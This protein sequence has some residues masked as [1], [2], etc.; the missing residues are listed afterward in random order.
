MTEVDMLNSWSEMNSNFQ[1]SNN[2]THLIDENPEIFDGSSLFSHFCSLWKNS[3][4]SLSEI[5]VQYGN[6]C[7][8]IVQ[9]L[10]KIFTEKS[11]RK[12]LPNIRSITEMINLERNTWNLI[13]SIYLDRFESETK[14]GTVEGNDLSNFNHSEREII[15]LLYE[16]DNELRETQIL[17]DWLERI[18]REQIEEVAEKYE[19]LFN[20]TTAW[21]NTAHLLSYLSQAELSK[22]RLVKE[23][24][25]DA[26]NLTGNELDQKDQI[27]NDR[28]MNYL[29]LCLRG[30]DLRR[31]QLLCTQRGEFWRAISL[32]GWRPFH[33]SGFLENESNQYEVLKNADEN[34]TAS[35]SFQMK[36]I[37]EGNPTRILYKSVCWWNAENIKLRSFERAIYAT[38]S[39]NLNV[40]SKILPASWTDQTWAHCR[41]LVE[42]RVDSSLRSLLNTGPR[43]DTLAVT[44][45]SSKYWP[46]D[47]GLS[48][49]ES[50]WTPGDWTLSNVFARVD[51]RLGW[52]AIGC[53][54]KCHQHLRMK[55]IDRSVMNDFLL[56]DD[57]SYTGENND[58]N[59]DAHQPQQT[60][61][62]YAI[63]YCIFYGVQQTIMLKNYNAFLVTLSNLMPKLVCYGL[64]DEIVPDVIPLQPPNL[65]KIGQIN[66]IVCHTLRFLTHFVLFLKSADSDILD[67]PCAEIIKA[68]LCFLIVNKEIDLIAYYIS[69]LS[70]ESVQIQWY[71]WFLTEIHQPMEREHCLSLAVNYGFNLSKL[72]RSIVKLSK[73]RIDLCM[74]QQYPSHP[75][76]SH[77][78]LSKQQSSS[79]LMNEM[80]FFTGL[81]HNTNNNMSSN[82][83]KYE[84]G[85]LTDLDKQRII[86]LDW[87]FYNPEQRGEALCLANSLLRVFIAMHSFKSAQQV[88]SK[89][90]VGTLEHAK[91]ICE[92]LNSPDWLVN[93]IRE[94]ECLILY[95]ESRDAFADWYQQVH[96]NRPVQPSILINN[97][98]T[99]TNHHHHHLTHTTYGPRGLAQ[100]LVI[101]ESKK[102]YL[103]RLERWR[104]DTR[105]DT[106]KAAEKLLA[107]LTYPYPGWLVNIEQSKQQQLKIDSNDRLT[108]PSTTLTT[109]TTATM[110]TTNTNHMNRG[111]TG[112]GELDDGAEADDESVLQDEI[113]SATH[114]AVV[115]KH[116]HQQ[117][118]MPDK[119]DADLFDG[120]GESVESR[121]LQMNV[122]R[123]TCITETVFLIVR[124]YQT[125]GLHQKCIEL[126]NLIVD[127]KFNLYKLFSGPQLQNLLH[128][129]SESIQ[130]FIDNEQ[131]PL[132][133]PCSLTEFT[134]AGWCLSQKT[135]AEYL[136]KTD[137]ET[138]NEL[139]NLLL[140]SDIRE[141]GS[142]WLGDLRKASHLEANG[143]IVQLIRLRNISIPQATE[144]LMLTNSSDHRG[145]CLLRFTFTDGRNQIS[146]LD[147]QNKSDLNIDIPPGTKFRLIG[148]IPLLMG[149][150]LLSKKHI[151]VLGGT[152]NNLIR[153]WN[154]TKFLKGTE[155]R[156]I[157]QGAP[158]FVPFGSREASCLIQTEG[159]FLNQLRSD[160]ERNQM[161]F[162]SFQMMTNNRSDDQEESELQTQFNEHRKEV[163]AELKLSTNHN[164]NNHHQ[165]SINNSVNHTTND[166][167]RIFT[168]QKS[169]RF[170]P[171]LSKFYE[172]QSK[173]SLEYDESLS[174]LL[175][176]G[177]P[178][179]L[180][181][182]A[183]KMHRYNYQ[184]TIDYLLS[185]ASTSILHIE[186]DGDHTTNN[187]NSSKTYYPNNSSRG[188]RSHDSNPSRRITT[189]NRGYHDRG[190]RGHQRYDQFHSSIEP[191]HNTTTTNNNASLVVRPSMGLTRLDD[192][193]VVADSTKSMTPPPT[194]TSST[195]NIISKTCILPIGCPI[196]AQNISGDYVEAQLIGHF[197]RQRN[198]HNG[199]HVNDDVGNC[200]EK[201][202]LVVYH[203]QQKSNPQLTIDE[204]EIVPINLIRTL[205]KEKITIDMV[206][207]AP[208]DRIKPYC[209]PNSQIDDYT[210]NVN[211]SD[212][213]DYSPGYGLL[214]NRPYQSSRGGGGRRGGGGGRPHRT[215]SAG[216]GAGGAGGRR[217]RGR[218]MNHF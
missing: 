78:F 190:H 184:A 208:L 164:N 36:F 209:L 58:V 68:Y 24:H 57:I 200:K 136:K 27:D 154:M 128:H 139:F 160:R 104:H 37:A 129:I 146:G 71:S 127:N 102:D 118:L 17:I 88:L 133:Y 49:P 4:T 106:E 39:G 6:A 165:E 3:Q 85:K 82:N 8:K 31:A 206:P 38:L 87:L 21:E 218:I 138:Y 54:E 51:A 180:A 55:S 197:P 84:I 181:N 26:V 176:L 109:T 72:T 152:V 112:G 140:N 201:V 178:F 130:Y 2:I 98:N 20:Q 158:M 91:L 93:T 213:M 119:N 66:Q 60:P 217:S 162:D 149:F 156:V 67:E 65:N 45:K 117:T 105:L 74:N 114:T 161:K 18:V 147:M 166:Q 14:T 86:A 75:V 47:G 141:Y 46:L 203:R 50:A 42:A 73:Q 92:K 28:L 177:Y 19:C 90:P 100:R 33:Y 23:L 216:R 48:L 43:A 94:H 16:R 172:I 113:E 215:F 13:S 22:H 95:L 9:R 134:N 10:P 131:D 205:N 173:K 107:L 52:S 125:A 193:I 62:I 182:S 111:G 174:K 15:R 70:N 142:P 148:S 199:V 40:L 34:I 198:L 185:K 192:L 120:L 143:R 207:P 61:S 159:E 76:N 183:L 195:S 170:Q 132:G 56:M 186:A 157:G 5:P 53:L 110:D 69:T 210:T 83:N 153:D 121:R 126:S 1:K 204:E 179:Q 212:E 12:G 80:E 137:H 108:T 29:F 116:P 168:H 189:T 135:F 155:N 41:A 202:V 99:N 79:I 196:L 97:H 30:G 194:L 63:V 77:G 96:N 115:V 64:G 175:S 163:L 145:P 167:Q 151:E 103:A 59:E 150:L 187:I 191:M 101:E 144:D 35:K 169:R 124:L 122:L 123:E 32:E 44:G 211:Q 7:H 25:P 188:I 11:H 89:L 171:G 214:P 81:L